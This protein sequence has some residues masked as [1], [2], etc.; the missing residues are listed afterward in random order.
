[1]N[2]FFIVQSIDLLGRIFEKTNV[3]VKFAAFTL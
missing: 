1:M 2:Y 3:P